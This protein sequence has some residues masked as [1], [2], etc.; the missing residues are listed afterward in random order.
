MEGSDKVY[1]FEEEV[2]WLQLSKT[3]I[4]NIQPTQ[5]R[6]EFEIELLE[7]VII[8][9]RLTQSGYLILNGKDAMIQDQNQ[10]QNQNQSRLDVKNK[11]LESIG[12][13]FENLDTLL[14]FLSPLY[15]I[16]FNSLLNDKLMQH[17]NE[18]EDDENEDK[19]Q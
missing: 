10:N 4:R 9:I 7:F 13:Y 11:V 15:T 8:V 3:G 18:E 6:D 5:Q 12:K 1:L 17:L 2:K 14:H 19:D 16:S